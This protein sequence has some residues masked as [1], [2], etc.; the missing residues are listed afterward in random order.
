MSHYFETPPDDLDRPGGYRL[1][2]GD[3]EVAIATQ[4]GVFSARRLDPGTGHL[5]AQLVERAGDFCDVLPAGAIVDLGCGAGPLSIALG[6]LC[7]GR[8]ILAVDVN[9]R[10]VDLTAANA[11]R[12]GLGNVTATLV[13][14]SAQEGLLP[15]ETVAGIVSN[16]PVRIGKAAQRVLLGAWFDRLVSGGQMLLVV[17]RHLGADSLATWL[18]DRGASVEREASKSGYRILRVTHP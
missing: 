10:A 18:R 11:A 16:P 15:D 12:A 14:Q 3:R 6:L 9:A 4:A 5:V 13:G 1:R 8:R 7:P 2:I 17:N